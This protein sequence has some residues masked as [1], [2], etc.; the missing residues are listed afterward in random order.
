YLYNYN[1][2]VK[3]EQLEKNLS[4]SQ[5]VIVSILDKLQKEN[6]VSYNNEK[7]EFELTMFGINT[8]ESLL[9]I[10]A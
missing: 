8:A 1:P 3:V 5:A 4:L 2:H 10:A 9:K 6:I 7:G